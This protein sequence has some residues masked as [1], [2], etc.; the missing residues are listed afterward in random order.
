[1]ERITS[2]KNPLIQHLRSLCSSRSYRREAGEF[3][4][5]GEKMLEEALQFGAD[6]K[7]V[8][9]REGSDARSIPGSCLVPA[10]LLQ[11]VSSME[12]SPGPVFSV[13]IPE[14]V[15]QDTADRVIVLENL[16]DPGNVGTV[17][18]SASAFGIDLV[19]LTG[20]CAD[21]YNPKTVRSTMGALFRQKTLELTLEELSVFLKE[22]R[23]PLIGAAL[24]PGAGDVR[25]SLPARCAVAIGN[26]GHGLSHELLNI[27][28]KTVII[29]MQP[30]S[31]SLNA[32][33]AASV[34]MWE[35]VRNNGEAC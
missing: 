6:I 13:S 33:V 2:R 3:L 29:P 30:C 5:D 1:M 11:Y 35:M 23:M 32:S 10:E 14:P 26:E 25:N 24:L 19:V 34:I 31:E 7:N 4:C 28:D 8:L 20:A 9:W 27:C 17:L 16:Q 18:R 15:L 21:L 22:A 12:N